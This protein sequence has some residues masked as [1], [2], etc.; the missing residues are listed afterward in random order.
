MDGDLSIVLNGNFNGFESDY[1]SRRRKC[2]V[3]SRRCRCVRR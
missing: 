3:A 1:Q 2:N